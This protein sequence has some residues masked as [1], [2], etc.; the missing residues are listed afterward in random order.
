MTLEMEKNY[1][2]ANPEAIALRNSGIYAIVI[3]SQVV[4]VGK[5]TDMLHRLM[6]HKVNATFEGARDYHTAKYTALRTAIENPDKYNIRFYV[7]EYCSKQELNKKEDYY[8]NMY[9][10]ELNTVTPKGKKA[11]TTQ[12]LDNSKNL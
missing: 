8:I 1:L 9:M 7:L 2:E 12:F 4:Y 3:N 10:P 5:S 6:S 11:V